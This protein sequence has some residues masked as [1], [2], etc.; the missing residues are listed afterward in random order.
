[1]KCT[2]LD[3]AKK[4]KEKEKVN[5]FPTAVAFA[6]LLLAH[7][8]LPSA[9]QRG[10]MMPPSGRLRLSREGRGSTERIWGAKEGAR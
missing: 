8:A 10:F 3:S 2:V 6:Q 1:M 4:E 5:V 9:I 7:L